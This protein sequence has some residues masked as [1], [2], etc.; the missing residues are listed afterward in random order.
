MHVGGRERSPLSLGDVGPQPCH[1][2]PSTQPGPGSRE[3]HKRRETRRCVRAHDDT[4]AHIQT[5]PWDTDTRAPGKEERPHSP[6]PPP[7]PSPASSYLGV[8][9]ALLGGF[10]MHKQLR[11]RTVQL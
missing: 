7:H 2:G 5:P 8:R 1:S 3:S 9:A 4:H 6:L 10:P 11:W